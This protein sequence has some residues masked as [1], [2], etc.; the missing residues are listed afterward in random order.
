[1]AIHLQGQVTANL[2]LLVMV[3]PISVLLLIMT[4]KQHATHLFS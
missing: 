1:M 2:V 3:Q 4:K